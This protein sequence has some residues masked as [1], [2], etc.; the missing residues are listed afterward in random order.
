MVFCDQLS[1]HSM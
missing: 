1:V